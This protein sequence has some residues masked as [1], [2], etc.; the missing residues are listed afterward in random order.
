MFKLIQLLA[1]FVVRQYE[2]EAARLA[3]KVAKHDGKHVSL[4]LEFQNLAAESER[5]LAEFLKQQAERHAE[6][7]SELEQSRQEL[8]AADA[9]AKAAADKASTV[10][11][12]LA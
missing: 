5:E 3:N 8:E 4:E 7:A 1:A 6:R 10:K 9:A 11:G 2:K 12:A